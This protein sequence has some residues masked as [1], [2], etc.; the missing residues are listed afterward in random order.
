M[1]Q[2]VSKQHITSLNELIG[3]KLLSKFENI[4]I[5]DILNNIN[6]IIDTDTI[7]PIDDAEIPTKHLFLFNLINE[8]H[9]AYLL[10][11]DT[12]KKQRT[13]TIESL[14]QGNKKRITKFENNEKIIKDNDANKDNK[15]VAYF[16]NSILKLIIDGKQ[17]TAYLI[18]YL[19]F[20]NKD[21]VLSYT[22]YFKDL[23]Y[24][25]EKMSQSLNLFSFTYLK[26]QKIVN[27][28]TILIYTYLTT[29]TKLDEKQILKFTRYIINI[30][31]KDDAITY[32]RNDFLN[33]DFYCAGIYN[34]LPVF[35]WSAST[36]NKEYYTNEDIK[37]L[38]NLINKVIDDSK[39]MEAMIL[40][41]IKKQLNSKQ[42]GTIKNL[43]DDL[44][45]KMI[46]NL[47]ISYIQQD[48]KKLFSKFIKTNYNPV[49]K[50]FLIS[51]TLISTIFTTIYI[52]FTTK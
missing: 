52:K 42:K 46:Y 45:K 15:I 23:K 12:E 5:E 10:S 1:Q 16:E 17:K 4:H 8:Y 24:V 48:H 49:K 51:Y 21:S 50:F 35:H 3:K 6:E 29:Y 34:N 30:Y 43:D 19:A 20:I 26:P 47:P 39:L 32:I 44:L 33:K 40:G 22:K 36:I 13:K 28:L 7:I 9:N 18:L 11:K 2:K 41:T 25:A 27:S 14:G 38:H 37:E 31:F